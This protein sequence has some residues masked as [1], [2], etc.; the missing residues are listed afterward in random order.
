MDMVHCKYDNNINV[1]FVEKTESAVKI[2]EKYDGPRQINCPLK[3][4][5]KCNRCG[6]NP[7]VEKQRKQMKLVTVH[8]YIGTDGKHADRGNEY[9]GIVY[10]KV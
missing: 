1:S 8:G 6:W 10:G 9:R 2:G 3:K 5:N 7:K 4:Q